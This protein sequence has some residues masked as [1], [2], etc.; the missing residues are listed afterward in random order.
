MSDA[1]SSPASTVAELQRQLQDQQ[2]ENARLAKHNQSLKKQYRSLE[3][4]TESLE[5]AKRDLFEQLRLLIENRFGPSSEKHRVE[6]A[7]MFFNEAETLAAEMDE[8]P[9]APDPEDE[10][11]AR[12]E[13]G[14]SRRQTSS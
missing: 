11:D 7:D 5:Q 3:R 1:A 13:A 9:Q 2:A 8:A 10:N 6:Q 12:S 14:G 4:K